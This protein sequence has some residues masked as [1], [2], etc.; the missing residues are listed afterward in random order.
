MADAIKTKVIGRPFTRYP[1]PDAATLASL[2]KRYDAGKIKAAGIAAELG[3]SIVT[4]RNRLREW[5]WQA[6]GPV[7]S[8]GAFSRRRNPATTTSRKAP[9]VK[10]VRAPALPPDF[11]FDIGERDVS[12]IA[13]DARAALLK[14]LYALADQLVRYAERLIALGGERNMAKV[15][16][17]IANLVK[18]TMQIARLE[19]RNGPPHD[20]NS[21][22]ALASSRTPAAGADLARIKS[23]LVERL[24][25]AGRPENASE[26][27]GDA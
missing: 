8:K 24:V 6:E 10:R 16:R 15:D 3:F 12:E 2:R 13:P 20:R 27:F 19:G 5:G 26:D 11:P 25:R 4:A 7:A 22:A 18:V 9:S 1:D 21:D 14:R 23:D 17:A